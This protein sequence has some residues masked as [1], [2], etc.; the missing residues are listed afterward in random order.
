MDWFFINILFYYV[1]R[2]W[3]LDE[4]ENNKTTNDWSSGNTFHTIIWS[5]GLY[6]LLLFSS[7]MRLRP[8]LLFFTLLFILYVV[9][10][11]R[12]YLLN[13]DRLSENENKNILKVLEYLVIIIIIV[14]VYGIIDYYNYQKIDYGKNFSWMKFIIGK[15]TCKNIKN[16]HVPFNSWNPVKRLLGN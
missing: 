10:T 12:I 13:R 4:E 8:N 9:N 16:T 1:G 14:F 11:Q 3:D 2:G 5:L 15:N 6:L 7:R